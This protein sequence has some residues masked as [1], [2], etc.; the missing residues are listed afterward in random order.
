MLLGS[1][2]LRASRDIVVLLSVLLLL[3]TIFLRVF[4]MERFG[5]ILSDLECFNEIEHVLFEANELE[6]GSV[7]SRE[8]R[9]MWCI[10]NKRQWRASDTAIC[11]RKIFKEQKFLRQKTRVTRQ[12]IMTSNY[13]T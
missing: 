5:F 12:N 10:F 13:L 6:Q 8:G 1:T 7:E 4:A 2:P 9:S 11:L 3:R